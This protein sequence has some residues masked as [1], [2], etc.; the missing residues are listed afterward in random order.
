M[1]H[2]YTEQTIVGFIFKMLIA[3]SWAISLLDKTPTAN[4]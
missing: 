3:L 4:D 1:N 2:Y